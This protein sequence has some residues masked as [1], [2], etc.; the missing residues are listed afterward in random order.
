MEKKRFTVILYHRKEPVPEK[1]MERN[2]KK[3]HKKW[4]RVD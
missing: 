2:K 3:D 4:G 1:K